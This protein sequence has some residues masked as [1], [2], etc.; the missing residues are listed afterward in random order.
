MK[1]L[2][3]F[4]VL[5]LVHCVTFGES[6]SNDLI[7]DFKEWYSDGRTDDSRIQLAKSMK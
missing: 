1:L 5:V 6:F 3:S 4:V 7:T 2:I